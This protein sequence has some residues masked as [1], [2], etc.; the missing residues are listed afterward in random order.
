MLAEKYT[1]PMRAGIGSSAFV[2][3]F[4]PCLSLAL[5]PSDERPSED[6]GAEAERGAPIAARQ[7]TKSLKDRP[8]IRKRRFAAPESEA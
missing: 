6:W 7:R 2:T 8:P 1:A 4:E 3:N 5:Q